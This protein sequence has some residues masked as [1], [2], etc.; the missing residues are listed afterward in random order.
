MFLILK[1]NKLQALLV[2]HQA[3]G[4]GPPVI[5]GPPDNSQAWYGKARQG[6]E[7]VHV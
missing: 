7:V 2:D 3:D 5:H 6:K 4:R 1:Q